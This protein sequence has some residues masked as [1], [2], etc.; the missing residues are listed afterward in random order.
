MHILILSDIAY[1][2]IISG[3]NRLPFQ[4][5]QNLRPQLRNAARPEREN[6]IPL[7]C[8]GHNRTHGI[9]KRTGILGAVST[10]FTNIPRQRFS[11]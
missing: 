2:R 3:S 5:F 8:R 1:A 4:T 7:M 10:L 6:H 9:G 11:R